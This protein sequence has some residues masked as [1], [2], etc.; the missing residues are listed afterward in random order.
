[1]TYRD[2]YSW[3]GPTFPG[4]V[5]EMKGSGT[6]QAAEHQQ[7]AFTQQLQNVFNAQY[8][9]Q[10]NVLAFLQNRLK[11]QV[12]NPQG[13][14]PAALAAMRA[15]ATDTIA[16]N[17]QHAEQ[18]LNAKEQTQGGADL[19][20]GVNAQLDAALL[21]QEQEQQAAASNNI[22]LQNEQQRQANYW[23]AVGALSGNASQENPLGYA[24]AANGGSGANAALS[25][26]NT[27]ANKSG[28]GGSFANAAGADVAGAATS[29][30]FGA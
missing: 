28:F 3:G 17:F 27:Q 11:P 30:L 20:S 13:F 2:P 26:A 9:N 6:T 19:P 1:M 14:A 23:R 24:E 25:E 5:G 18:A 15:Q 16:T 22:T 21:A 8:L 12:S 10:R 4:Y 7:L 29:A